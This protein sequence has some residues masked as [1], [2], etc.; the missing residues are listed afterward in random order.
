MADN[1]ASLN[2]RSKKRS[3][4]IWFLLG[5]A[6]I[7]LTLVLIAGLQGG[8]RGQRTAEQ[9]VDLT[10]DNDPRLGQ[11][12]NEF[13]RFG[14]GEG[15][16]EANPTTVE[17]NG[18]VL[19][20]AAEAV[21]TMT[22]KRGKIL[23]IGM[24]L[25]EEQEGG[26]LLAGTCEPNK[27]IQPDNS[28]TLKIMWNPTTLRQIQNTLTIRWREDDPGIF[29]EGKT[30]IV[31][32][33]QSTDSKDCVICET[34]CKDK[35]A[36]IERRAALFNG[37]HDVVD[38]KGQVKIGDKTYTVKDELLVNEQN[39]IVGVVEPEKIPLSLDNKLMGT[40]SDTGDVIGTD[41]KALG[42]LLGDDT[43]V[44]SSLTVL[45]AAVPVTSV[46][47]TQGRVIGK[48]MKDGTV[49]D[50]GKNVIGRP[51]VDGSVVNLEG[52][53]IGYLRPY[54]LVINWTGD[55]IGGVVSDGSIVNGSSQIIG[56]VKPNGL[57]VDPSGELIG[58][59]VPRGIAVGV[60]CQALGRVMPNGQVQ[61]GF[62]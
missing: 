6:L 51:M 20:S 12:P 13:N 48:V 22:A 5:L 57:A 26:F 38:T 11:T 43:I 2:E 58:G 14:S 25:A 30:E 32:K 62:S 35:E 3:N 46:M 29:D 34:P 60:A 18:V 28:C 7:I 9:P 40:I 36:K 54:G 55:V 8:Y 44:D 52:T 15:Y 31:L 4:R 59:V 41:G 1:N 47:N 17:M 23:F 39:Q 33:A 10:S 50:G 19:G 42:R 21:V 37:Q 16:L 53:P 61:N 45:G 56:A 24:E 49:V 27:V